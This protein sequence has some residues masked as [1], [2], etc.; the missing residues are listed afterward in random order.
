MLNSKSNRR[1][2]CFF[3]VQDSQFL[4]FVIF[5]IRDTVVIVN[6]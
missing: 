3:S 1:L 6:V 4:Q 5:F 2:K